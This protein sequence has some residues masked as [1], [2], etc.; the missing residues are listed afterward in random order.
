MDADLSLHIPDFRANER[1][2]QLL[3]QVSGRAGRGDLA[4]EVVVQSSTPHAD[5][6]QFARHGDVEA[7]LRMELENRE[8]FQYPPFRRLIRQVLRGPNPDKVAFF[9][10]QFAKQVE[11]RLEGVVEIRGPIPCPIEKMKDNYRFQNWYF[12]ANVGPVMGV[13]REIAREI[14]WP[15]DVVQV[16][17]ADPMMLS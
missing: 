12:T 1:T 11:K 16:L 9:G 4:G 2:F 3:V 5:P 10:E 17:D 13:L 14:A 8:R 6:I 15:A 7:F